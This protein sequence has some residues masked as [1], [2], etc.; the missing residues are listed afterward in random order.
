MSDRSTENGAPR[1]AVYV[2]TN[3]AT[4]NEIVGYR[5]AADGSLAPLGRFAT[6]GRG[7]G[8]PHLA[9][10]SSVVL[11]AD[12]DWLLVANAGSDELSL[13]AVEDDGLRLADRVASGGRAPTSVAAHGRIVYALNTG[14]EGSAPNITGFTLADG[15]LSPL[16]GSTRPLSADEADPA[17]ISFSPDGKTLVVTERGTNSISAYEID[18]RGLAEGPATIASSGAT[19]YGFDFAAEGAV[20][21]TEAFGGEIGRAAASSYAL[22][23]PGRL[24]P[25]SGSVGDTRSEVCWAAATKDGRFVYVT[26]FGD[27][28]IS[29]YR[30]GGDG[31]LE[32]LEPVAGSTRLGEPG[33]RDEALTPDGRYLYAIDADAQKIHGWTVGEDGR[34]APIGAVEGVPETV[35]GLAAS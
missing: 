35:A 6:G 28:T 31:A 21:V 29:S 34:L 2:Q 20:V 24:T 1:G 19:P 25:V 22:T 16:E 13:F 15:R 3:D 4:D 9:S 17:Q 18:E 27:G 10:Q 32:L 8:E 14:G 11:S 26:N 12:G 5:R 7:T 23:G 30:I 33:I